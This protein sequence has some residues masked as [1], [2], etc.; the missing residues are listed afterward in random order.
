MA[1]KYRAVGAIVKRLQKRNILQRFGPMVRTGAAQAP[2]WLKDMIAVPP[3]SMPPYEGNFRRQIVYPTDRLVRKHELRNPHVL[4]EPLWIGSGGTP[5]ISYQFASRQY[6]LMQKGI[7]EEDAYIQTEKEMAEERQS[8]LQ[9]VNAMVDGA[10]TISGGGMV[11]SFLANEKVYTRMMEWRSMM[12]A[13]PFSEWELGAKASLD[14]WL[15]HKV[16]K[17]DP[18]EIKAM[19]SLDDGSMEKLEEEV[20]RLRI[21]LF[22]QSMPRPLEEAFPLVS[23]REDDE[24]WA[25]AH[26]DWLMKAAAAPHLKDWDDRSRRRLEAWIMKDCIDE[27]AVL[28]WIHQYRN[29]VP[30]GSDFKQLVLSMA[31]KELLPDLELEESDDLSGAPQAGE[32]LGKSYDEEAEVYTGDESI[33]HEQEKVLLR[34]ARRHRRFKA[35][36]ARI[37]WE[38]RRTVER[39]DVA[40]QFPLLDRIIS[41][42]P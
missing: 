18:A 36:Q 6:E 10:K 16:M 37:K 42:Q 26:Q 21:A 41:E 7:A 4:K 3:F 1:R 5:S 33:L 8:K 25:M 11:P 27:T 35:D 9:A 24:E 31:L 22:P 15:Q 17:W 28:Q 19:R 32:S 38:Y 2:W 13:Q 40:V 14:H 34:A 30:L 39:G 23:C 29:T 12:E 20:A